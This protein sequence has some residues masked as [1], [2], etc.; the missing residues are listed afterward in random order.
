M[1]VS[2][3]RN[4]LCIGFRQYLAKILVTELCYAIFSV[5]RLREK[6]CFQAIFIFS[7][8]P[9]IFAQFSS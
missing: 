2:H 9:E 4:L 7:Y 1:V 6:D 8:F 3:W 5:M